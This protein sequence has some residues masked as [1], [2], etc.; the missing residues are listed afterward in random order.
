MWGGLFVDGVAEGAVMEEQ[1]KRQ[2]VTRVEP[3]LLL[4]ER[5]ALALE[6]IAETRPEPHEAVVAKPSARDLA[7]RHGINVAEHDPIEGLIGG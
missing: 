2:T 1:T 6:A 5:I 7:K 3:M 4:L